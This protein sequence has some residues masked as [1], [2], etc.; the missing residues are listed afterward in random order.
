MRRAGRLIRSLRAFPLALVLLVACTPV[1]AATPVETPTQGASLVDVPTLVGPGTDTPTLAPSATLSATLT[2]TP[3]PSPTPT[4]APSPTPCAP[5]LCTYAPQ[6]FLARPIAPENNDSVDITYR[7]G[8]TQGG[9]REPHH[10]V[11]F[12]NPMGTPVLAAADGLVVVAGDDS[13]P[14]SERGVWPITFYGP[15]SY[16]YGNLVIIEH[17]V[18]EALLQIFPDMPQ[19]VY[20]LYAHLSQVSVQPGQAV[21]AGDEIGQVGMAGVA[22]GSHLHFEVRLGADSYT[23]YASSHNPELWLIPHSGED[24]RLNGALAGRF[25]DIYG[26][27]RM[28][29][30]LT[31]EHLPD[32]PDQPSDQVIHFITYEEKAMLGRPLWKEGFGMGDLP[33]GLYRLSY[34]NNGL[35]RLLVEV[36]PGQLTVVTV[37]LE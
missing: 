13:Q 8:S 10:G 5:E 35:K 27:D 28:L 2:E 36:L 17:V 21:R 15:F 25:L 20:T 3:L 30:S 1:G 19:P 26:Q 6:F 23:G 22:L 16:F 9:L 4:N 14:T 12:L 34:P 32:G 31:L 33:P 7:F 29:E 11:E 37:Q 24:G 18:P